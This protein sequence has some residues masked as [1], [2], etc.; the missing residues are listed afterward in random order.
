MLA[1][2]ELALNRNEDALASFAKVKEL[3]GGKISGQTGI[4]RA[5][6]A[7]GDLEKA[8]TEVD[9][10]ATMAK[11]SVQAHYLSALVNFRAEDFDAAESAIG[12]VNKLVKSYPPATYLHGAIL[13]R[14]GKLDRAEKILS[15]EFKNNAADLNVRKL[16]ATIANDKNEPK[17][18]IKLLQP[19]AAQAADPQIFAMLGTALLRSGEAETGAEALQSA[20]DLAPDTPELRNQLAL[21]LLSSGKEDEAIEQLN[22][23][24]ELGDDPVSKCLSTGHGKGSGG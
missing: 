11:K 5:H 7:S 14:Q 23:A 12:R 24:V 16:L 15:R 19:V 9:S 1:E 21:G 10:L 2:I 13:Y 8:K 17:E 4:V 18:V 6:L 3:A 20:V 22:S